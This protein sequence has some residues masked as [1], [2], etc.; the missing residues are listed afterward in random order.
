MMT[1]AQKLDILHFN[2]V[3]H[4]SPSKEEPIGGA[5]RFA[6]ALK[7]C[8]ATLDNPLLLFSGDAFN[9]SL[10]GSITRGSHITKVLNQV[11]IDVACVG[12]HDFDFGLPQLRKLMTS[13]NFPWLFSNVMYE[14]GHSPVPLKRY[15]V[16]EHNG[17]RIGV[18]GL[19]EKEWI[20][21][22]PSFPSDLIYH[23]F[24]TVGKELATLL[25]DPQGPHKC[26]LVIA[27]THMRV[28]NDVKLAQ[29]CIDD[30]DLVLGG[31]DHFFYVS[32]AIDIVG[33]HWSRE[34]NL[35]DVGF[36]PEI[37][38]VLP[39]RVMKSGTDFREF[40]H[41]ALE[42]GINDKGR[43]VIQRIT[44]ERKVVDSSVAPDASMEE[45]VAEVAHLVSSKTAR[46][47]AYTT[48]P[49]EGRSTKVRTGETNFG[50]LT[51]DLML[52]SYANLGGELAICS[53]GTIRNDSVI[54]VGPL[55]LGDIMTA[56][57]FQDPTV[58]V[59]LTGQQIWDAIEN[60]LSQ[61]PKQEGRFPQVAGMRV[62]WSSKSPP[63]QRVRRILCIPKR[64][65]QEHTQSRSNSIL[66]NENEL[67]ERYKPENMIPLD[68]DREY[69]VV[70]RNY[71]TRGYD[72]YSSLSVSADK[73][74][75][76]NENGVMIG[77]LYRKFFLGLKYMNAFRE[78]FVKH[79][80]QQ[81]LQRTPTPTPAPTPT[82]PIVQ[83][84][85]ED[86]ARKR[87]MDALVASIARHW[88]KEALKMHHADDNK[89]V[90]QNG[91]AS[92][93]AHVHANP[94]QDGAACD[95]HTGQSSMSHQ[96]EVRAKWHC[97]NDTIMDALDGS[98]LGHPACL[99]S[100]EEEEQHATPPQSM[101]NWT[102]DKETNG[103]KATS[104]SA[105]VTDAMH[106]SWIQRWAS[107][108]PVIQG[109]L[110]QLD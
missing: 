61:Y 36:D 51:A 20:I 3:Y 32:R 22:I 65:L 57:P 74:V 43:K 4:V 102:E 86:L 26:D 33:D 12:N 53:G 18:I 6:T 83:D 38:N 107:I 14:D 67:L 1:V 28:P 8:R 96:M 95:C 54:D 94:A 109:R 47:I 11:D 45:V 76:D 39:V 7:A 105:T 68:M 88:R 93:A 69:V 19:V 35:N 13:T 2:D 66:P 31:H 30:I 108:A 64:C 37:N 87:H 101:Y 106:E 89:N 24:V 9:P 110:V 99:R 71:M 98:Q 48:V 49:L 100:E 104:K 60:G 34:Q 91:D 58:V 97:L 79:H 103:K 63:G 25:R 17:L 56:F 40:G 73:F 59:R 84:Q 52:A 15:H 72:G 55:T 5:S 50:N 10:E 27:L 70:T 44:A 85:S 80:Q 90:Q 78:H 16:L 23:D 42:I 41:L 29:E 75:V 77:T 62:E 82:P 92:V 81:E 21:T 46:P